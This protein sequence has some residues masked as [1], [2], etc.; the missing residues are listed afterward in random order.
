MPVTTY[1]DLM[2]DEQTNIGVTQDGQYFA[3]DGVA[4]QPKITEDVLAV[5]FSAKAKIPAE[6]SAVRDLLGALL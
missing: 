5:Y 2:V 1:I 4:Y 6:F 3:F